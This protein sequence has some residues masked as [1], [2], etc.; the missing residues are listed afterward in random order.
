[1]DINKE[2]LLD[3][4]FMLGKIGIDASGE[5]TRL[6]ASDAEKEGRDFVVKQMREA[7]LDVVVDRIGNI[8]GIWQTEENRKEAPLMIGSHIDTVIN[9]GQ[10]DGCYGVLTGIEIVRTLKE[11]KAALKRP[12]VVGAFTNEEGVRYQ[13]D[14]M[15]SLV[16]AG[17]LSLD[18]ALDSVGTDG[19]IL[20]DE[21]TR[22]GYG[23]TVDP[24]FI[25]PYAF[26]ELHI[27]QG[28][29]M[30]AKGIS[31]GAVE[32]LQGISWQRISI[33]GAANHAGTTPTD[34]R[35]D[36][37]LAA[38]KV[39]VFM[40]ERCLAS[41]GKTVCTVGTMALEPNAVN[42]IPSKAVFTVDVRNP[43]EEKLKEE[44][45]ALAAY[46]KKLEETDHVKIHTERLVRFEPVEFDNGI[47]KIT[48]KMAEKRGL[49]HCRMTSGAG[50]DAQMMARICPTAMIFVPSVKGISHNPKE[51]TRDE[52]LVGGAN[53]FLDIVAELLLA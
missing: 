29:I 8:F 15:G 4:I 5:R 31:I 52:D 22:I 9:A 35:I 36:A 23:G 48:E 44:E 34:M 24:G 49:S 16:Y 6:A 17:D 14:M 10:Y 37:G 20:R 53:V 18:E 43:N 3:S 40:R 1:M 39:N 11:Q 46:L 2:R 30:D 28:P 12:L 50:Q 25:K 45:M 7:G 38:S 41:S 26:I 33:E 47:C 42:V 21:L 27:E 19:T 32:N 13:P 51:Y